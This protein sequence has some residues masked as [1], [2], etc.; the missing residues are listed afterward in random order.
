MLDHMIEAGF[1]RP[2]HRA[3][4]RVVPDVAS[5]PAALASAPEPQVDPQTKWM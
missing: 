2:E 5:V 1:V 3:L 4:L